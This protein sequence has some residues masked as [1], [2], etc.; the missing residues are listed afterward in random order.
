MS[1][2]SR[3]EVIQIFRDR[4]HNNTHFRLTKDELEAL[5]DGFVEDLKGAKAEKKIRALC[6]A[7]IK[8]L[9]EGYPKPS[10][11]KYLTRYR[12]AIAT[13]IE[14]GS[15][16]LNKATSHRY[17]HQQRVTGI[18]EE[19]FEH[20]ALTYLKYSSEVYE[21]I[22]KR[23]PLVNRD[24][25]ID[26]PLVPVQQYLELLR[27]FLEQKGRFEARWLA[28]AI[29]GVTGNRFSQ[30][31]ATGTFSLTE[32]PY[33]LRY[34]RRGKKAS[35]SDDTN[36]IVTLFPAAEVLEALQ[37]L[38]RSPQVKA[39]A[40]LKGI[41]RKNAIQDF[42]KRMNATCSQALM[43]VVPPLEGKK[44]VSVLNLRNLYGAIT[45]HFFCPQHQD[46]YAFVEHFLGNVTDSPAPGHYFRYVLSD[47]QGKLLRSKG[48]LLD[49]VPELRIGEREKEPM[50]EGDD[51]Q[52]V[53]DT[54]QPIAAA[55][56][57]MPEPLDEPEAKPKRGSKRKVHG[58]GAV[59]VPDH[60]ADE[61]HEVPETLQPKAVETEV[62][63]KGTKPKKQVDGANENTTEPQQV[64]PEWHS[65]LERR[66]EQI[67]V[68]F[69]AQ[70]QEL[71]QESHAGWFVRR[72]ERLERENLKL[73]LE[74]NKALSPE[75]KTNVA[76]IQRLKQENQAI[77]LQ[78]KQAQD[79]LDSFRRL[80]FGGEAGEADPIG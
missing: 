80:L 71:R 12:K 55:T 6:E 9:E 46:E 5:I 29:S 17:M 66:L 64:P 50:V 79:K 68:E 7:E 72:V 23:S 77:A 48:V 2:K 35:N 51:E 76:E 42:E 52:L 24:P 15:L 37:R 30:S 40:K 14:N 26:L 1:L 69:D 32:H 63:P 67:R 53:F 47:D 20:W 19:R 70:L 45:V 22:D 34:T 21:S 74:R 43:Q 44:T 49:K 75:Q 65:E 8:L 11:A 25:Q 41:S 33:L 28:T 54:E 38:R 57:D 58:Y 27:G 36:E 10:V 18:Q 73:R 61:S 56:V 78:L 39:I 13:A 3:S 62:T 16:P 31:I 60:A 59:L 4:I